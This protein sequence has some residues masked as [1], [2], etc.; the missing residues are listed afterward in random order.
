MKV[1]M[2][3]GTAAGADGEWSGQAGG[4]GGKMAGNWLGSRP[5]KRGD[6]WAGK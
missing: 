1:A 5:R 6:Q 4:S 2:K 3:A